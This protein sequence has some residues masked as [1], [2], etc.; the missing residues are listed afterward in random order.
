MGSVH[1]TPDQ[2]QPPLQCH[3]K[4]YLQR[5]YLHSYC[6][7]RVASTCAKT[8][9]Y[10]HLCIKDEENVQKRRHVHCNMEGDRE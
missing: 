10:Y 4:V 3:F 9:S 5:G 6:N 8:R 7:K 1:D 2:S